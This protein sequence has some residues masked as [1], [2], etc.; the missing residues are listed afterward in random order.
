MKLDINNY[1]T[2]SKFNQ[3][4]WLLDSINDPINSAIEK[5]DLNK[6]WIFTR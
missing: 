2:S 1:T 3:E 4:H 5:D 6:I